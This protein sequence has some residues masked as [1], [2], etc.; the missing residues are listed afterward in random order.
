[1][2]ALIE[3]GTLLAELAMM[4]AG[5]VFGIF[6]AAWLSR[7]GRRWRERPEAVR[8]VAYE[9]CWTEEISSDRRHRYGRAQCVYD[10]LMEADERM[11]WEMANWPRS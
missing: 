8:R 9:P 11:R 7:W 1:M 2:A 4:A 5:F 3:I 6:V 10:E